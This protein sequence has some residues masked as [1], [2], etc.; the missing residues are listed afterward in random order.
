MFL[1]W[2]KKSIESFLIT[3]KVHNPPVKL[4]VTGTTK[5]AENANQSEN[6]ELL[7]VKGKVRTEA[8]LEEGRD[9]LWI[10]DNKKGLN[11]RKGQVFT[12]LHS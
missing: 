4:D 3:K 2:L 12:Y 6:K 10:K 11:T 9:G 1:L 8:R 5:S 7:R